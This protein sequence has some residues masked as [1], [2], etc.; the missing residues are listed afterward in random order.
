MLEIWKDVQGYEGRY[1]V[2]N[3][4]NVKSLK[5]NLGRP[6][7][8]LRSLATTNQGYKKVDLH[9]KGDKPK[10]KYVHRLVVEAFLPNPENKP[11]VNHKDS[12]PSNNHIENLE[13][14]TQAEN[15]QHGY[16]EGNM[17]PARH[18]LGA[19]T[20]QNKFKHTYFEKSRNRWVASVEILN[21]QGV[22]AE[23]KSFSIKKYGSTLAELLAAQAVNHILEELN[24]SERSKNTFTEIEL[25]QLEDINGKETKDRT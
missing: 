20:S 22:R 2:S 5:D 25:K 1:Q 19:R 12:N 23:R 8:K 15:V 17:K 10:S 13:W 6:R 4:G 9:R 21:T 18:R 24:D 11:M 7:E 14:C 16:R 3:L